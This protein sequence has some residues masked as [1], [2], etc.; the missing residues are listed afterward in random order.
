MP[1]PSFLPAMPIGAPLGLAGAPRGSTTG[2]AAHLDGLDRILDLEQP[3]LWAA[4]R[5]RGVTH[6]EALPLLVAKSDRGPCSPGAPSRR[7]PTHLKVLTPRSYSLL[8]K[9]M[10][11]GRPGRPPLAVGLSS[12]AA[13]AC[14]DKKAARSK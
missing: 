8:V 1:L 4:A 3:T 13:T 12:R 9:N 10:A 6:G 7:L 14:C 2:G 11:S 5:L